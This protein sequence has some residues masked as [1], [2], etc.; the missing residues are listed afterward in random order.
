[1]FGVVLNSFQI[2]FEKMIIEHK[3]ITPFRILFI[4]GVFEII[5]NSI[6]FFCYF[7]LRSDNTMIY[8]FSIKIQEI[9]NFWLNISKLLIPLLI[10]VF[11][12]GI[13][14]LLKMMTN[15]KYNPIF[16]YI[17]N[18][19]Y[20]IISNVV[21]YTITAVFYQQYSFE[22]FIDFGEAIFLII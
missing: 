10:Y 13:L 20:L 15:A 3:F 16:V 18:I 22:V 21:F 9:T 8:F 7:S 12:W 4:E 5:I 2:V 19:I 6:V 14:S 17:G 1:M 11:L